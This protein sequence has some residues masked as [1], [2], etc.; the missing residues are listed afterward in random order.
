MRE[1]QCTTRVLNDYTA[2]RQDAAAFEVA[3]AAVLAEHH[4]QGVGLEHRPGTSGGLPWPLT[5]GVGKLVE[6]SRA[7]FKRPFAEAQRK[8]GGGGGVPSEAASGLHAAATAGAA[9][10]ASASAAPAAAAAAPAMP[11]AAT[12]MPAKRPMVGA[13]RRTD[14]AS[15]VLG[16]LMLAWCC[17]AVVLH[18]CDSTS[19]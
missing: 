18:C 5:V 19:T 15:L 9:A 14:H 3:A 6:Q 8:L 1:E 2:R 16:S 10:S 13:S 17:K 11:A 4:A 7:H 12:A